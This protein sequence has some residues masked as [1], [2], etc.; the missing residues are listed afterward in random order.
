MNN[1]QL[2]DKEELVAKIAEKLNETKVAAANIVNIFRD[3]VV[4]LILD[5]DEKGFRVD[6]LGTFKKTK[7]AER[8]GRNPKTGEEILIKASKNVSF[9]ASA[10]MKKI[11][12]EGK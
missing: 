5:S 3:S 2:T 4:E 1:K 11:L 12:N 10:T 7:R 6:G 8:K 9:Q